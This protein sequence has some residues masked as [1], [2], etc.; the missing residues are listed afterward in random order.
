[1]KPQLPIMTLTKMTKKNIKKIRGTKETNL[2]ISFREW[3]D[4]TIF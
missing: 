1:M 3:L 2:N 4:V